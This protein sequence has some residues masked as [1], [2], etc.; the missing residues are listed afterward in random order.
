MG[1]RTSFKKGYTPW[2]KGLKGLHFSPA[3]EFKKG[4]ISVSTCRIGT[5]RLRTNKRD[6]QLQM[7]K[8]SKQKWTS[9]AN[10]VWMTHYGAVKKSDI[11]IHLNGNALDDRVENLMAIPREVSITL[12]RWHRS[13][14]IAQKVFYVHRYRRRL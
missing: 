9:L 12:N 2:N 11:V 3:T 10:R 6:G 5:I 4:H 1:N 7:I 8:V 13:L 14:T